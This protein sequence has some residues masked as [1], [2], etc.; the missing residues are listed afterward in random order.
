MG[1]KSFLEIKYQVLDRGRLY[2]DLHLA[3]PKGK[4]HSQFF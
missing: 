4:T 2:I 3:S 1:L